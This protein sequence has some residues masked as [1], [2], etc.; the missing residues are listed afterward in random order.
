MIR[1][2]GLILLAASSGV[3][4]AE[5]QTT[6]ATLCADN[7]TALF[8]CPIGAKTLSL[9]AS[10]PL[11]PESGYVQ[12]R[13]GSAAKVELEFPGSK[14][15]PRNSLTLFGSGFARGYV[16][17]LNFN[18]GAYTY[19]V[20]DRLVGAFQNGRPEGHDHYAGVI[21]AKR[22]KVV[23]RLPCSDTSGARFQ[24]S[25]EGIIPDGGGYEY[26]WFADI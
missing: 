24:G 23:S 3:L 25:F 9:C 16:A 17:H 7:E 15:H 6:T 10:S 21:V 20:Y 13:F 22:G 26:W 11:T 19:V 14:V 1:F 18:V 8:T 4:S 5:A 12:Y 2:A